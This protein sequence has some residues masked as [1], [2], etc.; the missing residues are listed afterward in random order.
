MRVAIVD[1]GRGNLFSVSSACRFVGLEVSV[2]SDPKEI[3]GSAGVILPGVG[4]FGDAM[5]ALKRRDLLSVL[6]DVVLVGKPFMGIC[7]GFQILFSESNEFGTHPGLGV[8]P[9]DVVRLEN[10]DGDQRLKIPHVGWYPIWPGSEGQWNGTLLEGMPTGESFYFV[11]SFHVRPGI[12]LPSLA[13]SRF[14]NTDYCAAVQQGEVFGCQFHPERSGP[15]GL[16]I[17]KAF[18][19]RVGKETEHV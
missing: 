11:H 14:S 12:G 3:M 16:K 1:C 9:G 19:N 18:A 2:T 6:R 4:A 15:A 5:A 17:Y 13:L 8:F 7:L 10:N